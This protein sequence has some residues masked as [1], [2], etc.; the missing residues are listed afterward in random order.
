M[1]Y[2]LKYNLQVYDSKYREFLNVL[3]NGLNKKKPVK[4]SNRTAFQS[5]NDIHIFE[6]MEIWTDIESLKEYIN[7]NEFK[8]LRGAFQLLTTIKNFSITELKELENSAILHNT[9]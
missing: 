1:E 5:I 2:Q 4:C 9:P 3:E 8:S 6:Y 7:S